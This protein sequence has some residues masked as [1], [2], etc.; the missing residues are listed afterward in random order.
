VIEIYWYFGRIWPLY[1]TWHHISQENNLHTHLHKD[2]KPHV[3]SAMPTQ[4]K[5]TFN[6]LLSFL[7]FY[8]YAVLLG[9]CPFGEST[10]F[11]YQGKVVGRLATG[12]D[13]LPKV[14]NGG[15][16]YSQTEYCSWGS[17]TVYKFSG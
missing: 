8:H 2:L 4:T 5:I 3:F 16:I 15:E 7:S 1:F 11:C 14:R 12:A 17:T 6:F 13:I 10:D 9:I